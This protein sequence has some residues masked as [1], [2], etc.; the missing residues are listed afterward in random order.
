MIKREI[1]F[2]V[3]R[4]CFFCCI[5][6]LPTKGQIVNPNCPPTPP[7][8]EVSTQTLY[9]YAYPSRVGA[10]LKG[11]K[12]PKTEASS[13]FGHVFMRLEKFTST[14]TIINLYGYHPY[15]AIE[16]LLATPGKICNDCIENENVL[17]DSTN[18]K[19]TNIPRV[20]AV[21]ISAAQ[22]EALFSYAEHK[23]TQPGWYS[24]FSS[25]CIDFA[26]NM[27]QIAGI[28]TPKRRLINFPQNYYK[29]ILKLN[30][31]LI[32]QQKPLPDIKPVKT[33]KKT[34][35]IVNTGE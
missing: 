13:F 34:P 22:Y 16:G 10:L 18:Q 31:T 26:V 5:A 6:A 23:K 8:C 9:L 11:K 32:P 33:K 1:N 29:R 15:S 17:C 7:A 12:V 27:L 20:M 24:A 19:P 28:E 3:L 4:V 25:N 35:A 2:F 30:D 21:P 14:D